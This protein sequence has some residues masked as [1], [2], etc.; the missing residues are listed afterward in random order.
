MRNTKVFRFCLHTAATARMKNCSL[1]ATVSIHQQI[2]AHTPESKLSSCAQIF[3]AVQTKSNAQFL[4]VM[5]LGD[6]PVLISNTMVK[7]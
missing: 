1:N 3:V 7:T 2:S 6:T 4:V 5:R